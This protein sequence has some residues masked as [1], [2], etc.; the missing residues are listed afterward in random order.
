[1]IN[2]YAMLN[3]SALKQELECIIRLINFCGKKGSYFAPLA[4]EIPI[5]L[6]FPV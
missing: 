6:L 4:R 2:Y 5:V 3:Q 1:M